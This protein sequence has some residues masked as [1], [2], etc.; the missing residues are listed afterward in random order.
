[1]V[2]RPKRLVDILEACRQ[3]KL[4]TKHLQF[5]S[6]KLGEIPNILLVHCV[7]NGG[8][9]LKILKPLHVYTQD[10]KY[11]KEV[12]SMYEREED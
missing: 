6:P 7:K 11:S 3:H 4:E 2:H 9:E 10:G 1:M 12:L 8:Q 5:I